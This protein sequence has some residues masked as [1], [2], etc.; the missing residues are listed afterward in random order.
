ME[1]RSPVGT[2]NFKWEKG[3]PVVKYIATVCRISCAKNGWTDRDAVWDLTRLGPRKHV[4]GGDAHWCH[5]A[6]ITEPSMCGGD[7]A[8]YKITL[9]TCCC[10]CKD[11]NWLSGR[12][13]LQQ[14]PDFERLTIDTFLQ[15]PIARIPRYELLLKRTPIYAVL[16]WK[17]YSLAT[18]A[19]RAFGILAYFHD[20]IKIILLQ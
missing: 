2:G 20:F 6:N 3:R 1:S 19:C 9:T 16:S 17:Y 12:L 14:R 13:W 10:R 4:L 8:R 11:I 7:A 15:E 18:T 5:L